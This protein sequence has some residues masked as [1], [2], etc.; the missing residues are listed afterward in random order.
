M[1]D[2][3][4][5]MHTKRYTLVGTVRVSTRVLGK[6]TLPRPGDAGRWRRE[7]ALLQSCHQSWV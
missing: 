4:T 7:K 5:H 3:N 6:D 2:E 1:R